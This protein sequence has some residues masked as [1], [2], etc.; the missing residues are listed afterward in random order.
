M[1]LWDLAAFASKP[2]GKLPLS[3]Q[4]VFE[5]GSDFPPAHFCQTN[6]QTPFHT[7]HLPCPCTLS[8]AGIRHRPKAVWGGNGR[9]GVVHRPGTPRQEPERNP[10]AE[11]EA[12]TKEDAASWPALHGLLRVLI[13]L[14]PASPGKHL[15]H[16]A[17]PSPPTSIINHENALQGAP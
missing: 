9:L 7:P 14:K 8:V 10:E 3:D 16:W 4:L 2:K 5:T 15:P 1:K 11:S 13:Q 17:G 6:Q 12:E